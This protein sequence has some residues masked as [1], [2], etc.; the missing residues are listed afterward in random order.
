MTTFKKAVEN[1]RPQIE[2]LGRDRGYYEAYVDFG[3]PDK[4]EKNAE[5]VKRIRS[6]F[7]QLRD[8]TTA[9][10]SHMNQKKMNSTMFDIYWNA[11]FTEY[12]DL[13]LH[14]RKLYSE[15]KEVA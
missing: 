11:W 12:N 5:T 3:S 2:Q 8:T 9:I 6:N 1:L 14:L 10:F 4:R 7:Y 13:C 15:D